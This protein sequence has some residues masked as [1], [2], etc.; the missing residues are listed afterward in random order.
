MVKN[1]TLDLLSSG[2]DVLTNRFQQ[3]WRKIITQNASIVEKK[4]K[5]KEEQEIRKNEDGTDYLID[6]IVS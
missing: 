3:M 2:S 1:I 5:K 6:S 4:K